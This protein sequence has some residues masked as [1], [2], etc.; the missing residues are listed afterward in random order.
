M[1]IYDKKITMRQFTHRQHPYWLPNFM[2]AFTWPLPFVAQK[3]ANMF[4]GLLNT[5]SMEK[6]EEEEA[7]AQKLTAEEILARRQAIKNKI[8][9]VGR[10]GRVMALLREEAERASELRQMS[11]AEESGVQ[12]DHLTAGDQVARA[13]L[14]GFEDACVLTLY[15]SLSLSVQPL[16]RMVLADN[17]MRINERM[18][19]ATLH[20]TLKLVEFMIIM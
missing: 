5:V 14:Y 3:V 11:D 19:P 12:D 1:L 20:T 2:D 10:M 8:R 13:H 4:E 16:C 7:R 9:K 15:S 17:P 18:P 6:I